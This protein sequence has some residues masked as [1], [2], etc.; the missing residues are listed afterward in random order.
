VN[1]QIDQGLETSAAKELELVENETGA[2]YLTREEI[3][4]RYRT[5]LVSA[6]GTLAVW[7]ISSVLLP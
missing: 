6:A 3:A 5:I 2:S 1:A 7:G 4:G